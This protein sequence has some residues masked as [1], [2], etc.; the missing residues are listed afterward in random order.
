MDGG[1][2]PVDAPATLSDPKARPAAAITEPA[3]T[4]SER[5][6]PLGSRAGLSLGDVVTAGLRQAS[7]LVIS[8]DVYFRGTLAHRPHPGQADRAFDRYLESTNSSR[9]T[10]GPA[11]SAPEEGQGD[12]S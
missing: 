5:R 3:I 8:G 11:N 10:S 12:G 6:K 9:V 7:T 1:W 4:G 2:C